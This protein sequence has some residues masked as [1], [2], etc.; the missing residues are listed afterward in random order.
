MPTPKIRRFYFTFASLKSDQAYSLGVYRYQAGDVKEI[1]TGRIRDAPFYQ[2]KRGV[3]LH[4]QGMNPRS[5]GSSL[6]ICKRVWL[7][8]QR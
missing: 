3:V 6:H 4:G 8:G 2:N 7:V 1:D 5:A